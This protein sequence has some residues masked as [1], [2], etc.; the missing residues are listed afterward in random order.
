MSLPPRCWYLLYNVSSQPDWT[1]SQ[2]PQVDSP[3]PSTAARAVAVALSEVK[4]RIGSMILNVPTRFS[5]WLSW[6]QVWTIHK[7][8]GGWTNPFEKYESNWIISTNTVENN[9]YLKLPPRPSDFS[10]IAPSCSQTKKIFPCFWSQFHPI[11][12]NEKV[13]F[14]KNH[15]KNQLPIQGSL[16]CSATDS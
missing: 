7:L 10:F 13:I 6:R 15:P 4:T 14:S 2:F 9:T 3:L 5:P 16:H 11:L 12:E 8:V 1:T